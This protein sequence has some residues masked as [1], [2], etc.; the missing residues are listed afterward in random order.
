MTDSVDMVNHPPHYTTGGGVE[1]IEA[2]RAAL[3]E[4]GYRAYCRGQVMKY[5]W[6]A[7]R[8][9]ANGTEDYR[10]AEWYLKALIDSESP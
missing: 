8:K 2:I 9:H 6:R 1:C 10:K 4:E 5:V 7:K 3:G